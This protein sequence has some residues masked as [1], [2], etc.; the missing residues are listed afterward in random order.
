MKTTQRLNQALQEVRTKKP[1]IHHITNYVTVNDCANVTL[2][3][4]ASPIMADAIE[5]VAEITSI[6]SGLV[7]NIGTL[8]ERTVDSMQM[9]GQ[10][11]NEVGIPVVFDPV[12]AGASNFRNQTT[13][14]LL[15]TV[16]FSVIRGNLS[17]IRYITGLSSNTKGVDASD[18]DMG[19][20]LEAIIQI[21]KNCAKQYE[22]AIAITGATDVISNG[23][24]TYCIEN[25][26]P[27]LSKISGTGC[28]CNSL[29]AS[30]VAA[31]NDTLIGTLAG[32]L[33]MGL[34]GELAA[35]E[36]HGTGSYHMNIMDKISLL[37]GITLEEGARLYE[38]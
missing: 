27:K 24:T 13:K 37:D 28:M 19:D 18:L 38:A 32:V 2:A 10:K 15:S 21:A 16:K 6:A 9:A 14:T 29:I 25:G 11:A 4:G 22:A 23:T 34:A 17:E 3:I 7:L 35:K 26:D 12:G 36:Y 30:Y 33:T 31:T 20:G 8:N 5:E 1:L